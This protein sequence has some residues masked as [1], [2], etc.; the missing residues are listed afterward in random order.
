MSTLKLQNSKSDLW[1]AIE[2]NNMPADWLNMTTP[3]TP[4][5]YDYFYDEIEKLLYDEYGDDVK[6]EIDGFTFSTSSCISDCAYWAM[7]QIEDEDED[8]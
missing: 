2:P 5:S 8:N 1:Y 3:P 6:I 7:E 4:A